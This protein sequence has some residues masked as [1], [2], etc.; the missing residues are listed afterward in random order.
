MKDMYM[1]SFVHVG[2]LVYVTN[3]NEILPRTA[4]SK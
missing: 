3:N 2:Q 1:Q 4:F